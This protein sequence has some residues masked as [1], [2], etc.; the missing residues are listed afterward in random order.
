MKVLITDYVGDADLERNL[1]TIAGIETV[2][3]Q[4]RNAEE[5]ADATSAPTAIMTAKTPITASVFKAFPELK[6]IT[7]FGASVEHIDLAAAKKH[8]VWVTNVPEYHAEETAAHTLGMAL[9]LIRNLTFSDRAVRTGV[10][11]IP[12][13][14]VL[15]RPSLLTLGLIGI[16]RVGSLVARLA[17]PCF[18]KILGHDPHLAAN[19]WPGEITKVALSQ[20]LRDS[21]VVSL[22]IPLN[23]KTNNYLDADAF[24][25]M[26]QGSFIVNTSH[27]Q[28]V[29]WRALQAAL[30]SGH[31]A[32]AALDVA[33]Q[34]P[35]A[36]DHRIV[37][38]PRVMLSPHTAYYS[39]ES[40][41]DCRRKAVI[42]ILSWW[43]DGFPP[44]VMV[45]G[46]K[47]VALGSG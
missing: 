19:R 14:P 32:G 30:D 43:K 17:A 27:G 39:R 46:K 3:A 47:G 31:I 13:S 33:P 5:V 22:H 26:K 21:D 23:D 42:N 16:G 6:L 24:K 12:D 20:L 15:K 44:N 38:H 41:Q 35:P 25:Q 28:H 34:E 45:K 9:S 7:S 11:S 40:D 36:V 1:F 2:V 4:C 29:D 8:R 37:Q 18:G 10:W